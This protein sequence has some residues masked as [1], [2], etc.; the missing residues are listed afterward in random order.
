VAGYR[1]SRTCYKKTTPESSEVLILS[2][3]NSTSSY[4][5]QHHYLPRQYTVQMDTSVS[6]DWKSHQNTST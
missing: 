4:Y 5:S 6:Q 2:D 1:R 3:Y